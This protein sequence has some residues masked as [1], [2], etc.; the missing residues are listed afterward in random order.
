[1]SKPTSQVG[2]SK[3]SSEKSQANND[4]ERRVAHKEPRRW[5]SEASHTDFLRDPP[6]RTRSRRGTE[7]GRWFGVSSRKPDWA[8]TISDLDKVKKTYEELLRT[9]RRKLEEIE[10][11]LAGQSPQDILRKKIRCG[12]V[13]KNLIMQWC[14]NIDALRKWYMKRHMPINA[15]EMEIFANAK[16]AAES[17]TCDWYEP[18][19]P[20]YWKHKKRLVR[21]EDFPPYENRK[22]R[23]LSNFSR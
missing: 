9:P 12:K 20:R 14:K 23:A 1:M 11:T 17:Y 6:D 13:I 18:Y 16:A 22:S 19:H 4:N 15:W 8:R 3:K 10:K 7:I 5:R 2:L 21:L